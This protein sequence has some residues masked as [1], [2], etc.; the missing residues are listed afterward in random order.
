MCVMSRDLSRDGS[1]PSPPGYC[2]LT[3]HVIAQP[4]PGIHQ[5]SPHPPVGLCMGGGG[6]IPP[7]TLADRGVGERL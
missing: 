6:I 5:L 7:N 2:H 1:P 4:V 3:F